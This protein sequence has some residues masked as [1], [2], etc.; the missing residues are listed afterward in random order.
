MPTLQIKR[1]IVKKLF[2]FLIRISHLAFGIISCLL[3]YVAISD[4]IFVFAAILTLF[5]S[6]DIKLLSQV[7]L[8]LIVVVTSFTFII[9]TINSS[10]I[11]VKKV[12]IFLK[13]LP[14]S[15]DGFRIA[16][17]SDL[18]IGSIIKHA[19]VQKVVNITNNLQADLIALTGDFIDGEVDKLRF[20]A[21]PL[22]KLK[23]KY[24][25][26]FVT[27]NHEYYWGVNLWIAEF[28]RLGL[29]VLMNE[30]RIIDNGA[31]KIAIAGVTDY[32]TLH[33][34]YKPSS[35]I[36][37]ALG[38]ENNITKILL[39]H[40][41]KSYEASEAAGFDLQLSGHTHAGQY[42]P[43]T[44]LIRFFQPFYKGLNRYKNMLIYVNKGTGYWGPPLRTGGSSEITMIIL[45]AAS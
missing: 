17:I 32:Y 43:F 38:L 18:H 1:K 12:E 13:K 15:F 24:G 30:N 14:K 28:K 35:P 34:N 4:I 19:Y 9:G 20:D 25:S 33:S 39:A 41:P 11:A 16:Q 36:Q 7:L 5:I 2:N 40:Q 3:V 23:S 27:G 44:F 26:F 45:R 10:R 22:S 21:Q 8:G 42:F 29:D 37:A 6:I 31:D